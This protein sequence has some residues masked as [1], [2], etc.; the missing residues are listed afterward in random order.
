MAE[1]KLS[2]EL[3]HCL[4]D[5]VCGDCQYHEPET[6]L[7]CK[8]LLQKA[9]EVVKRYEE[10][11]PCNIG[12]VVWQTEKVFDE[13]PYLPYPIKATGFSVFEN[14]I[15]LEGIYGEES[16]ECSIITSEIG[17]SVFLTKARAY[18]KLAEYEEMEDRKNGKFKNRKTT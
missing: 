2:E 4:E 3:R 11:F 5:D 8:D 15:Y 18:S 16:R 7:I 13:F 6:K 9:Y 12:D 10:M 1:N 14:G 17:K